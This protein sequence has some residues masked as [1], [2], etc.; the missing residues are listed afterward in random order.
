MA[1]TV[2]GQEM[3]GQ[4]T[5][6]GVVGHQEMAGWQKGQV[7]AAASWMAQAVA[8]RAGL[9]GWAVGS[10]GVA[11][12]LVDEGIVA[13]EAPRVWLHQAREPAKVLAGLEVPG[14]EFGRAA[15]T[16]A[17]RVVAVAEEKTPVEYCHPMPAQKLPG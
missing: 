15:V 7:M 13:P 4:E 2:V 10:I 17:Q 12:G 3:L 6:P 8:G 16:T 1:V 11:M 9:V 14:L 5:P